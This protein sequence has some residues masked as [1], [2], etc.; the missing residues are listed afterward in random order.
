MPRTRRSWRAARSSLEDA[1]RIDA[2]AH[3]AARPAVCEIEAIGRVL[4]LAEW[5]GA[6]VHIAHHSAADS[7]YVLR[8]AKRRG[9][10]VTVETCPQ[11]LLLNTERHA[12]A[13]RH[14]AR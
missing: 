12:Q 7:L 4:T 9:V 5:T 10:D 8:D 11:Y 2:L 3:L 14:P 6:R 1:G 13:R